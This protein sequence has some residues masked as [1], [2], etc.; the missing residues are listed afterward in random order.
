MITLEGRVEKIIFRNEENGYTVAKFFS[1]EESMVIVGSCLL[2]EEEQT[3]EIDGDFTYHPK[4]GQQFA[5]VSVRQQM[6]KSTEAMV[7]YLSSGIIPYVGETMAKRI[8]EEFG[9]ETMDVL[10]KSPERLLNIEGIGPKKFEKIKGALEENQNVRKI[11][12]ELA[13]FDLSTNLALK[14]YQQY[15]TESLARIR[16]NPY[17]LTKDISGMGFR[18]ADAMAISMGFT[19]D[20]KERVEAGLKYILARSATEGHCYLPLEEL[21]KKAQSLLD[22]SATTMEEELKAVALDES[23][24]IERR[25]EEINCYF[26]PY[27]RAENFVAGRLREL[28][29]PFPQVEQAEIFMEEIE[30]MRGITLASTQR[31]AVMES[32][33]AGVF[34]MTGGP[35]TGKTTTLKVMMDLFERYEKKIRLCAPTGRAAKRMQEATGRPAATIHKLLEIQYMEDRYLPYEEVDLDCDVV[36]VDEMSMVDILLM[37]TLLRSI[38]PGMHLILVGD[39]HQ[40][41]S[42]GAGNVLSDLIASNIFPRV[43]LTEIFRQSE[44]SMIITNAHRIHLGKDPIVNQKDFFMISESGEQKTLEVLKDLVQKRLPDYYNLE[45]EEIQVL[46]PMKKGVLGVEHLNEILQE[47]LNPQ[48]EEL[49]VGKRHFR[50]GDRVMQIKNNYE[51]ECR[52]ESEHYVEESKGVFNG[53]MGKIVSIDKEEQSVEVLY[54]GARRVHYSKELLDELMLSYA[55]TIHKSQG[56]EFPVI[57]IPVTWAPPMLLT[58]NLIYTAI[59]RATKL[60]V[61][62]GNYRYLQQMI[63]NNHMEKRYSKLREKLVEDGIFS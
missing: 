10:E 38:K 58:R 55:V 24:F 26:A 52:I 7:K 18:K 60:V 32:I 27:L 20:C 45:S 17:Q 15:G 31:K 1:E 9:Q 47:V 62:V 50:R 23:F 40:L 49:V 37:E 48:D 42:V 39:N 5:F 36:I 29:K 19:K 59:T 22:L 6:P 33:G 41:P 8:V 63:R 12:L 53:D 16:Q 21:Q 57:V 51:L 2:L 46:A 25:G 54:D 44:E 28:N 14:I 35:G 43:H 56:S 34:I 61:L 11:L 13:E 30:Q 3:Y 4:F